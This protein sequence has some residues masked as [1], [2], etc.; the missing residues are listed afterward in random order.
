MDISIDALS[1]IVAARVDNKAVVGVHVSLGDVSQGRPGGR[2]DGL[3]A[4]LCRR[5]GS[6]IQDPM[7][8]YGGSFF[9]GRA[10]GGR[11][12]LGVAEG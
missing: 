5:R 4:W 11:G 8:D 2:G 6:R 1:A 3:L 7:L 9:H 10:S 12:W